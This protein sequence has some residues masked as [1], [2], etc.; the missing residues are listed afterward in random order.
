MYYDTRLRVNAGNLR[1]TKTLFD[2]VGKHEEWSTQ[3]REK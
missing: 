3:T 2:V 1:A